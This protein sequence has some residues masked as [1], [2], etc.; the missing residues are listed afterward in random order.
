MRILRPDER[1]E[2][3]RDLLG[4]QEA[5]AQQHRATH[6]DEQDGRRPRQVLGPIDLEVVAASRWIARPPR[7]AGAFSSR[8][9]ALASVP[10][11]SRWNGSPNSYGLV[12][13]S[14]LAAAAR[15]VA[16]GDRRTR[17]GAAAR[18]GRR[19]RAGRS[20]G[21]RAGSAPAGRRRGSGSP[22]PR[23][24]ARG[25]P[26]RPARRRRPR[27]AGRA[28][29]RDRSHRGR[30]ARRCRPSAILEPIHR[31][32]S[33]DLGSA[34]SSESGSSPRNRSGRRGRRAVSWS[35][36]AASSARSQAADRRAAARPSSTRARAA[37]PALSERISDCIAAIRSAS[38]SMMSSNVRAPGKNRPWRAR[39]S[40]TSGSLAADPLRM[41]RVEIADHL[42]VRG[43]VLRGHRPM[44]SRT[45]DELLEHLLPQAF[46][47]LV[48]AAAA[49]RAPGSRTRAGRGSARRHRSAGRR[50]ARGASL[51]GRAAI[52]GELRVRR[53]RRLQTALDATPLRRRRSRRARAGCRPGRRPAEPLPGP[54]AP[55]AGPSAAMRSDRPAMSGRGGMVAAQRRGR[56]AAPEAPS[57]PT[58][59]HGRP[60]QSIGEARPSISSAVR[61]SRA[62]VR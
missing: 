13:S 6:V 16:D 45:A 8:A 49:R 61:R 51:R 43:Q 3:E 24:V 5:A 62:G 56:G 27:R 60:R 52:V 19:G 23:A 1:V 28:A 57:S 12:V 29:R 25:R 18:R 40:L 15:P 55:A 2:R 33:A 44:A 35:R 36:F 53:L 50:A 58:R 4:G 14:A 7:L 26:G 37:G 54:R 22:P 34:P 38:C 39:N 48:E 11:R 20:G 17:R 10:R 42:A 9:R 41:Q 46:D 31:L 21:C 32:Q 47:E 59:Q 30:P